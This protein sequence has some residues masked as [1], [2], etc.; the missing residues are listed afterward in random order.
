VTPLELLEIITPG[1]VFDRA[2]Q[3]LRDKD[4]TE[5]VAEMVRLAQDAGLEL[6]P[7][8]NPEDLTNPPGPQT[9]ALWDQYSPVT[10]FRYNLARTIAL[11]LTA[12]P[13]AEP[14]TEPDTPNS[15]A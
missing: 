8:F 14:S 5:A 9:K 12:S 11:Q 6:D 13:S 3:I 1:S 2:E 4:D 15:P 10:R 7:S